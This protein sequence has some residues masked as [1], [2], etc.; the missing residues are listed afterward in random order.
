MNIKYDLEKIREKEISEY[1]E[2]SRPSFTKKALCRGSI[3]EE[4]DKAKK[5]ALLR[6]EEEPLDISTT[7]F[8]SRGG[9]LKVVEAKK[10]CNLCPVQWE[11]FEYAYDGRE[12]AGIW[13][14]STVDQREFCW[15]QDLEPEEAF[16]ELFGQEQSQLKLNQ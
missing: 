13:G 2:R 6:N 12:Q 3:Y 10:I 5:R 4:L 15:R 14:G 11:C 16:V 1:L 9:S 8:P 7:F